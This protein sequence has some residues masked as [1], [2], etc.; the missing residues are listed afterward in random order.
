MGC[1]GSL[2]GTGSREREVVQQKLQGVQSRL[3]VHRKLCVWGE[4]PVGAAGGA[5]QAQSALEARGAP[6]AAEGRRK[7]WGAAAEGGEVQSVWERLPQFWS[8]A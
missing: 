1:T 4:C 5:V 6:E 7:L 8:D 2:V 3:E